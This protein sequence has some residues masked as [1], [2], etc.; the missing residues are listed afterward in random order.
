M[1]YS[2]LQHA[3]SGLRW[4]VLLFLIL[5]IVNAARKW[6]GVP[7]FSDKDKKLNLFALIF[8]HVQFILGLILY[9]ISP[10]VIFTAETMSNRVMRY[11]AVEHITTMLIA[12]ALITIGYS[13]AKRHATDLKKFRATFWFYLI[14][15]IVLL[16]GIPWPFMGLGTGWF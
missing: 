9:F 12:I 16:M 13:R 6:N 5:A 14:G 8:T 15:L 1:F 10:K 3:H 2:I 4:L 11:F 7:A